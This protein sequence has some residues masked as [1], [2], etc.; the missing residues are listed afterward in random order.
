MLTSIEGVVRLPRWP[1]SDFGL[2]SWM[3]QEMEQEYPLA[4]NG[5][6]WVKEKGN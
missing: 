1:E 4:T 6:S 2:Q 3:Y 5:V